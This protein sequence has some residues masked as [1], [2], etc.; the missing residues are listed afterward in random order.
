VLHEQ[1]DV[2]KET[3]VILTNRKKIAIGVTVLLGAVASVYGTVAS[4]AGHEKAVSRTGIAASHV[5]GAAPELQKLKAQ[6]SVPAAVA[7]NVQ[8]LAEFD[9]TNA[10][11]ALAGV[12]LA[13]SGADLHSTVYTFADDRG[14]EC[15]VV[16]G[17]T[18]FCN[19]D[20][21]TPT[22][23]INWSIGGGDAQNPDRLIALYSSNVAAISLTA[24]GAAVP[25]ELNNNIA[26]G[27]FPAS[28]KQTV[29]A[30]TY[31]DGSFRT[32]DTDLTTPR[33]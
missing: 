21:G 14:N 16:S 33:G 4:A 11:N 29:L 27:E 12:R 3:P 22:A 26:Y 6:T 23:G 5:F 24:D 10:T 19:P 20:G 1:L 2:T 28:T 13:R 25:V 7:A 15:V 8:Q 31:A 9:H 32:I 17:E 18:G 30:V